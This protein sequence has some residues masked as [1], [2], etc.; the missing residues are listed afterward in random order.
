VRDDG[1]AKASPWLRVL[2]VCSSLRSLR[3]AMRRRERR[4]GGARDQVF[5]AGERTGE[6]RAGEERER[7]MEV[8]R[9]GEGCLAPR[10]VRNDV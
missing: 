9:E 5:V 7:R 8:R 10:L 2:R 4:G 3:N 1:E 6:K